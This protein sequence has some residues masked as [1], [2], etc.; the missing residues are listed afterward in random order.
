MHSISTLTR[1]KFSWNLPSAV[2]NVIKK[3]VNISLFK[4]NHRLKPLQFFSTNI[5][6]FIA[7]SIPCLTVVVSPPIHSCKWICSSNKST[8]ASAKCLLLWE[9]RDQ[10]SYMYARK[11]SSFIYYE[12]K[13]LII[14]R[15]LEHA[16]KAS[17]DSFRIAI[18]EIIIHCSI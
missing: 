4:T 7:H 15:T 16:H 12:K 14:V 10:W 1:T 18:L 11:V 13:K 9:L 8:F 3:F 2:L 6:P 17:G 5:F